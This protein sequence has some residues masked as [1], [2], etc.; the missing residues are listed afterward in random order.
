RTDRAGWAIVG[1][2]EGGYCALDLGLLHRDR[3]VAF[4]DLSG[5]DRPTYPGGAR[6]LF[7]SA[8]EQLLQH[9]PRLV[10]RGLRPGPPM[11]A[12][13]EV[14]TADGGNTRSVKEMAALAHAKGLDV[15][16]E[17][18]P[19]AHHTWRVW[20]HSFADVLPWAAWKLGLSPAID[21]LPR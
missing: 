19:N 6:R 15:H 4:A 20:R 13:F 3:Y 17:L 18:V 8:P 9:D 2:S 1:S 12:W 16:L 7:R 5:L 14:G 11:S 21:P 10:L